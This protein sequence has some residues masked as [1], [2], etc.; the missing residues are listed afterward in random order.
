MQLL[1]KRGRDCG[2]GYGEH[3]RGTR[4]FAIAEPTKPVPP[5]TRTLIV[6]AMLY[7][8]GWVGQ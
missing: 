2:R 3:N 6:A 8:S 5:V 1:N 4:T 7:T